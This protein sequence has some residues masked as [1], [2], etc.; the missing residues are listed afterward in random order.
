MSDGYDSDS[1]FRLCL[2]HAHRMSKGPWR[3]RA[4]SPEG[5]GLNAAKQL[6]MLNSKTPKERMMIA[7][8]ASQEDASYFSHHNPEAEEL[9]EGEMKKYQQKAAQAVEAAET[10]AAQK[11]IRLV[12]RCLINAVVKEDQIWQMERAVAHIEYQVLLVQAQRV[13]DHAI[14]NAASAPRANLWSEPFSKRT[15]SQMEM[16][17]GF[18]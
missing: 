13:E 3:K 6:R 7:N 14:R 11:E 8:R 2:L 1:G 15:G 18:N 17:E 10:R 12:L 5:V 9:Q 16:E 4:L